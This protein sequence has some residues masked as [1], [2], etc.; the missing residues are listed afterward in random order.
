MNNQNSIRTVTAS[1]IQEWIITYLVDELDLNKDEIDVQAPFT[2]FGLDSSTAVI[3]T[4]DLGEWLGYDL[5]PTLLLDYPTLETLVNHLA[6][7]NQNC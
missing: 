3:L 2:D 5:D 4:G 6:I 7:E 1:Q